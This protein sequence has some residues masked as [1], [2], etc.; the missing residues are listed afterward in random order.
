[1]NIKR[2]LAFALSTTAFATQLFAHSVWIETNETNQLVVRFAEPT[3]NLERSPGYLDSLTPPDAFVL[4]TNAP[5]MVDAPKKNNHFLLV[6][7]S[8]TNAAFVETFFTV[9]AARKPIFYARWHPPKAGEGKPLLTF[10]LVPTGKTGEAR[11]YFRGQPIG[12]L[13]ATLLTPKGDESELVAD[14]SGLIQ[15]T[16]EIPGQYL[17]TL[18]HHREPIAGIHLGVPYKETSHNC[19]LV[20]TQE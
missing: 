2:I 4:I 1:M 17:L 6:N 11:A 10:D 15:V 3:G 9:R 8:P 18:A 5:V 7:A 12:G 14:A 16:N 19:S 20:W 13:K